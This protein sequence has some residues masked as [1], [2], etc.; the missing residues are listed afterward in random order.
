MEYLMNFLRKNCL[1]TVISIGVILSCFASTIFAQ[2]LTNIAFN[3]SSTPP[4]DL[5]KIFDV[6][7]VD[8]NSKLS[9]QQYP[10]TQVFAYIS[11]GEITPDSKI[12]K[13]IP[14]S[15]VIAKNQ[16]WKTKVLDQS[17]PAWQDFFI[18][19]IFE[20]L[21][22]K[23]Y[24]GFFLDTLDSYQLGTKTK[25][26][27]QK[28]IN[29]LVTL[30]QTIKQKYPDAKLILNRGFELLPQIHTQVFAVAAESLFSGWNQTTKTY[31]PI[32]PDA[33]N[34][35]LNQFKIAQKYDLPTISIDY[36]SPNNRQ[37]TLKVAKQ[38]KNLNIIPYVA[39][40]D[41]QTVGISTIQTIPRKIIALYNKTENPDIMS[42]Y[43]QQ[44]S[45]CSPT[46]LK[47]GRII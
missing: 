33:R 7:V 19:Q 1:I 9:P 46:K 35:L 41:L 44:F 39:D 16:I 27:Q 26:S 6:V 36:V 17:N 32:K 11:V 14:A 10:Q 29:G 18:H 21:W 8:P 22:Q 31:E 45:F 23:G 42:A 13:N 28:Q 24:R 3:Y 2:P 37:K 30:I 20:P 38:I 40:G 4:M 34:W 25:T 43:P 47:R 5:L 15:W 12:T